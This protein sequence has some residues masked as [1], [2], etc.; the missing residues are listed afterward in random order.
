MPVVNQYVAYF[1]R[2][3]PRTEGF[4]AYRFPGVFV[5]IPLFFIFLY[6]G[7]YLNW[8]TPELRPF[9]LLYF[10][11]GLYVGRDIAVYAHYMPLITLAVILLI[12]F[13]PSLITRV[14]EPLKMSLG[15]F[16]PFFSFCLDLVT[17]AAYTFY[18]RSWVRKAA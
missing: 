13:S 2:P 17:L 18:V 3:F 10:I 4:S 15:G 8:G 9:M 14:L 5:H 12:I 11:L 16:F 6:L 7:L 1:A